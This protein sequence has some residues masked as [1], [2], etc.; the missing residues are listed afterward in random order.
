MLQN[1]VVGETPGSPMAYGQKA[2]EHNSTRIAS[3]R[4]LMQS[5]YERSSELDPCGLMCRLMI[6]AGEKAV[7]VTGVE[8]RQDWI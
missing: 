6:S 4:E 5:S 7:R 1:E 3:W 2:P 8:A